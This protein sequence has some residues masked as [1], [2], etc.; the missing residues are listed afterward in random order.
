MED[1]Q[2]PLITFLTNKGQWRSRLCVD[3][4]NRVSQEVFGGHPNSSRQ[5]QRERLVSKEI[6]MESRAKGLKYLA[7]SKV[8]QHRPLC[9]SF[10]C[11]K[12]SMAS[13]TTLRTARGL[14]LILKN[15][16]NW[17]ISW[18]CV[19]LVFVLDVL[20]YKEASGKLAIKISLQI[21]IFLC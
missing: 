7:F 15:H 5:C 14:Y 6:K 18:T 4:V 12:M 16:L 20:F 11:L 1:I 17:R 2:E 21:E 8:W 13:W 9:C 3:G 19:P 10:F